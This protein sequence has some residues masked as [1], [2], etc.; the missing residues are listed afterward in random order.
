MR[1]HHLMRTVVVAAAVA[2]VAVGGYAAFQYVSLSTGIR[3]SQVLVAQD[4]TAAPHAD[5]NI[6][7]MGLDSRLDENG[8]PLPPDI[9]NALHAGD[10]SDG[11][12]NSNVLMLLHVPGDGSKATE[13]S[14]PRDD[15]VALAGCPDRECTGKIK[16]AYG[17][18]ADQESRRIAGDPSLEDAARQQ[19]AR[20]A[21]R[22]AQVE[23][24]RNFL[25]VHVDHFVEVTM[26]AFYQ[27][28][29]VIQ[30]I[31][32]CVLNDTQD[33]YSGANFHRGRQQIDAVQA[34]AFVRQRRD[35]HHPQLDFT[36]LDRERRQQAFI[37][38]LATQLKQA[39]TLANPVKLSGIIDVVK[40]NTA[41]D[42]GL[43]LVQFAQQATQLAGGNVT[44]YTLPIERFG[45][46]A[47]GED[48]NVV[49]VGQIRATVAQLLGPA[50]APSGPTTGPPAS[51]TPGAA[52]GAAPGT[53]VPQP[54]Q[55]SAISGGGIP[56]VK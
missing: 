12:L 43:D 9:Y 27:L 46:N 42:S 25:G 48:V 7:V 21:G 51:A 20:D 3:K 8:K 13:I 40:Q 10:Q 19:K 28:A 1:P 52:P 50:A 41:I 6:L 34:V 15:E 23:T 18:A 4:A 26:V 32:V 47:R 36:D 38:S 5:T 16:Q 22:Q 14:I 56:C 31:T 11:G 37:V 30:P 45:K 39:G 17:L 2:I 53:A 33:Q 29:Q 44:F 35:D 54:N 49:D 55:L 24:V